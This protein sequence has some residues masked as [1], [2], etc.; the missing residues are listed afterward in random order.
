MSGLDYDLVDSEIGITQAEY[1]RRREEHSVTKISVVS[2]SHHPA[3]ESQEN[4]KAWMSRARCLG[5]DPELF[6][7]EQGASAQDA[8]ETCRGCSV[9]ADCLE[10]AVRTNQNHGIWGGTTERERRRIKRQL[11]LIKSKE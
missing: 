9:Q 3:V 1:Y 8:K 11:R 4:D 7:P 10:Y 6:H 5:M 2:E